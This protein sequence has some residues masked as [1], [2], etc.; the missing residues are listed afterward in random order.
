[1]ND[2]HVTALRV[3]VNAMMYVEL[4]SNN[5]RFKS[6]GV[7]YGILNKKWQEEKEL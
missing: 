7:H 5:D 1:M 4:S 2:W 3:C 6:K